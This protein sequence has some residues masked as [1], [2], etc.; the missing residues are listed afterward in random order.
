MSGIEVIDEEENKPAESLELV[1]VEKSV[2]YLQ[3]N[4]RGLELY[5]ENKLKEYSPDQFEGNADLAKKKRAE[6]NNAKKV[7]QQK[8]IEI[9]RECM[10]P[11]SDF[12]ERCKIL[13]KQVDKASLALDE[14]VKA[15]ENEEKE[16]KRQKINQIWE[17][18]K[19]DLFEIE[20]VFNQ[21]WLN[22]TTKMTE[23]EAEIDAIIDRT[24][25][26]LKTIERFA[27]DA[28]TL[29]AH[30]LMNL[31]IAETMQYGDELIRQKEI[32][33]K[34]AEEREERE[35][36]KKLEQQKEELWKE[37]SNFENKQ[38][39][40]ALAEQAIAV[41]NGKEVSEPTR[42]EFV[43]SIKCYDEDL[44]KLKAAMNALGIE[45]SVEELDF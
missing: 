17:N 28:E 15:K 10:K 26:D 7:L 5:V 34:E 37:E 23:I 38:G 32:A 14:I 19:F 8:R 44:L 11:F 9:I 35:Y 16:I 18:K 43:V 2:G 39:L 29:K 27:D 4:I 40:E 25:K 45:Y 6:L 1:V 41:A 33:Q 22:K 42:K 3:T 20:K 24:Y 36:H 30:Y 12:E 21:K 13:E 31:D